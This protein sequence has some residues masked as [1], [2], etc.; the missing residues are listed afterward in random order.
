MNLNLPNTILTYVNSL[1]LGAFSTY[2][3]GWIKHHLEHRKTL[4]RNHEM[5][6]DK[7]HNYAKR[8]FNAFSHLEYR[9]CDI[10]QQTS[11][12]DS[13]KMIPS[14]NN[15]I[16]WYTKEGYYIT[17]TSYLLAQ[18]SCFIYQYL[19]E[20]DFRDYREKS[21]SDELA[22]LLEIYRK[23]VTTGG[24]MWYHYYIAIGEVIQN[25][26]T[27]KPMDICDFIYK[28]HKDPLFFDFMNQTFYF[29][30]LLAE[31]N[32]KT[33]IANILQIIGQI[34]VKIKESISSNKK[35]LALIA[36]E[37]TGTFSFEK[38]PLIP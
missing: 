21:K 3:I 31:N 28:L 2:A 36:Y 30:K 11:T 12:I 9:F 37:E 25:K 4:K 20:T 18:I 5:L 19:E 38:Y 32:D 26:E 22:T 17:S 23:A 14:K 34:K 27:S 8:M 13:L 7:Y 1:L 15:S 24:V 29:V 10:N 16:E 33:I 35:S 6:I